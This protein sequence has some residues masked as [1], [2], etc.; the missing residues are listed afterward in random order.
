MGDVSPVRAVRF[1][2][3]PVFRMEEYYE[4]LKELEKDLTD[5]VLEATSVVY[6]LRCE[7][8]QLSA[9]FPNGTVMKSNLIIDWFYKPAEARKTERE[10]LQAIIVSDFL[11][12]I[13]FWTELDRAIKE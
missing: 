4:F 2:T 1:T 13:T 11:R 6:V 8:R 5:G 9:T 12:D 7:T 10:R 3:L